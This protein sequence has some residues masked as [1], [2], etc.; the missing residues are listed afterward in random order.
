MS[1]EVVFDA[2]QAVT[3]NHEVNEPFRKYRA[4]EALSSTSATRLPVSGPTMT[5]PL[6]SAE[7]KSLATISLLSSPLPNPRFSTSNLT[8]SNSSTTTP[9]AITVPSSSSFS[10]CPEKP[11]F[12]AS[13][14]FHV[15][16]TSFE[17]V[18]NSVEK[19]FTTLEDDYD[20]SY[21]KDEYL[22]SASFAV[23]LAYILSLLTIFFYCIYSGN[24]SISKDQIYVNCMYLVTGIHD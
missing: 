23:S 24:A 10:K 7:K 5:N 20:W 13:T 12:L 16:E 19:A 18:K 8:Q 3:Y 15:A 17:L 1:E 22:V 9:V 11:T 6:Q 4:V 2:D 21:F 14:A